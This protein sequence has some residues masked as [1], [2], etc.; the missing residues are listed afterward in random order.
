YSK[1]S[2]DMSSFWNSEVLLLHMKQAQE[3]IQEFDRLQ[4]ARR[5]LDAISLVNDLLADGSEVEILTLVGT[6][7]RR[8]SKL[9]VTSVTT[10]DERRYRNGRLSALR[11]THSGI[12]HCCTFCSSGGK[13][14]VTCGCRARMP[15][16]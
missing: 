9:G 4:R 5:L 12:Y 15:G 1:S 14:E 10:E 6:I 3:R 8:F 7:A 13:K 2:A 11:L 16:K